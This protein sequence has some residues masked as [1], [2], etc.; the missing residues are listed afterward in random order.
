MSAVAAIYSVSVH[1]W[2]G[3]VLT[4]AGIA[5]KMTKNRIYEPVWK[6]SKI[7]VETVRGVKI[8]VRVLF[9]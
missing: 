6:N 2:T 4:K 5:D 9:L 3:V 8:I 1:T 7:A